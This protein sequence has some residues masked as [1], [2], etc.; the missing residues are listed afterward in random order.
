MLKLNLRSLFL[1]LGVVVLLIVSA[2]CNNSDNNGLNSTESVQGSEKQQKLG[3][4]NSELWT[5]IQAQLTTA[6]NKSVT[7]R[8]ESY[9]QSPELSWEY[10]L[11][12]EIKGDKIC[13]NDVLY[14]ESSSVP[15]AVLYSDGF[16]SHANYIDGING[17]EVASTLTKIK[18][19][20]SC[21]LLEAK[22]GSKAGQTISVY[23][24]DDVLYFVSFFDNG[25]VM[26]IHR[27]PI[28]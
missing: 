7:F 2:G 28:A 24:I 6:D 19:C 15:P 13:I 14:K 18:N 12:I 9:I 5:K 3:V 22:S 26:R 21:Y 4:E 20:K 1:V 25:E 11:D 10:S 17:T 23:K 8:A 27:S 16:L